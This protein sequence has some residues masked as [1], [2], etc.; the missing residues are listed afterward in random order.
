MAGSEPRPHFASLAE[1]ARHRSFLAKIVNPLWDRSRTHV[2]T[3]RRLT[4]FEPERREMKGA[5]MDIRVAGHQVDTGEA[6]RSACL[7]PAVGNRRPLFSAPWRPTSPLAA[8]PMRIS[9]ATLSLGE[10]GCGTEIVE[11]GE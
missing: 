1:L 5:K 4:P 10:P 6:L 2:G 8:D 11:P 9:R 7:R 3:R